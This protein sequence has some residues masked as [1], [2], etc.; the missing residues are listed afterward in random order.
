[1]SI[2]DLA[3]VCHFEWGTI[4]KYLNV[5]K[6]TLRAVGLARVYRKVGMGSREGKNEEKRPEEG[7]GEKGI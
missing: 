1:M 4:T 5:E 7:G 3:L 6:A 2:E